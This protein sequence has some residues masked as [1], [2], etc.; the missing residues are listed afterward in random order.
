MAPSLLQCEQRLR[1][2]VDDL[3]ARKNLSGSYVDIRIGSSE[4]Y[5]LTVRLYDD[6]YTRHRYVRDDSSPTGSSISPEPYVGIEWIAT[7]WCL[8][9]D[10]E[11]AVGC[12]E[13]DLL[14]W[15]HDGGWMTLS[16][17]YDLMTNIEG[18]FLAVLGTISPGEG[19]RHW[20]FS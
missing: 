7:C 3:V 10:L 15:E 1:Q 13:T 17:K 8:I 20:Q 14:Q 11:V 9:P 19:G 16:Y 6:T 4:R 18:D 5:A 2:V 12:L